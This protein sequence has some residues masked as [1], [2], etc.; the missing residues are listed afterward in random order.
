[1]RS[2]RGDAK[3]DCSKSK[4]PSRTSSRLRRHQS[5]HQRRR[6]LHGV[7][8]LVSPQVRRRARAA[9]DTSHGQ[10][11]PSSPR[12][13]PRKFRARARG[14]EATCGV[15]AH[16][17]EISMWRS[18]SCRRSRKVTIRPFSSSA[19][20]GGIV[21]GGS[22]RFG[23]NTTLIDLIVMRFSLSWPATSLNSCNSQRIVLRCG[24]GS[25][26]TRAAHRAA[27]SGGPSTIASSRGASIDSGSAPVEGQRSP[28][29]R[30]WPRQAP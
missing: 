1:M 19:S 24:S 6:S 10:A 26:S 5:R 3:G 13:A 7:S 12:L 9:S 11:T 27:S 17:H 20:M 25:S 15:V 16:A 30:A 4:R 14:W 29:A 28:H 2:A 23:A 21:R 22:T 18:C 8:R